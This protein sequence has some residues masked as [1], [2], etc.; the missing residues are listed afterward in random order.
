ME[1]GGERASRKSRLVEFNE[2]CVS[3]GEPP[4]ATLITLCNE[5][6]S[7]ELSR[8]DKGSEQSGS[9]RAKGGRQNKKEL[10]AHIL[11]PIWTA[12]P[13]VRDVEMKALQLSSSPPWLP[14]SC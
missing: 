14:S 11:K 1:R 6:R 13:N 5:L 9:K 2:F 4:R 12:P 3:A 10:H 7:G 8:E